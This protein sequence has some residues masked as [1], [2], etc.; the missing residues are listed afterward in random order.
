MPAEHP[1]GD[2]RLDPFECDYEPNA[3]AAQLRGGTAAVCSGTHKELLNSKV[4]RGTSA[5]WRTFP[6]VDAET[7]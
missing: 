3:A 6:A 5:F 1:G 4:N 7:Q 2:L